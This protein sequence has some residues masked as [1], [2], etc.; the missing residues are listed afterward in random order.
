M[1]GIPEQEP[2]REH[3]NQGENHRRCDG[4][5]PSLDLNGQDF[6]FAKI[7]VYKIDDLIRQ[8]IGQ[9]AEQCP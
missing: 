2:Q 5:P 3:D 7:D 6:R 9:G 8:G 1:E 4:T